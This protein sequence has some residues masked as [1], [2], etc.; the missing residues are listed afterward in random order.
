[1]CLNLLRQRDLASY[2]WRITLSTS[3]PHST[4]PRA[5]Y[6]SNIIY[7]KSPAYFC[8]NHFPM[9][10]CIRGL[11]A[12]VCVFQQSYLVPGYYKKTYKIELQLCKFWMGWQSRRLYSFHYYLAF[13]L[14]NAKR[15][16][17]KP[18]VSSV[19]WTCESHVNCF[20]LIF[21]L[22]SRRR[23]TEITIT[24]KYN[25]RFF[26]FKCWRNHSMRNN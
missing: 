23:K 20:V 4:S 22:I 1:M 16:L 12:C 26:F 25:Q 3:H 19:I 9:T 2:N 15:R 11:C 21:K 18:T 8:Q 24:N 10:G 13:A 6:K 14:L 5:E 17:L 7:A